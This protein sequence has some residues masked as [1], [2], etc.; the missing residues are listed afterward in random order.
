MLAIFSLP[1][2]IKFLHV[3]AQECVCV[4]G[5]TQHKHLA[6]SLE[7]IRADSFRG[8]GKWREIQCREEITHA[9]VTFSSVCHSCQARCWLYCLADSKGTD[10]NQLCARWQQQMAGN[11]TS[12]EP[13]LCWFRKL[14][15]GGGGR[16]QEHWCAPMEGGKGN[17]GGVAEAAPLPPRP[18]CRIFRRGFLCC[19]N[20]WCFR[21]PLGHTELVAW[22]PES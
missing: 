15:W 11:V 1:N 7:P 6:D 8:G 22:F 17:G 14:Q 13:A 10:Q 9:P 3:F 19:M 12:G 4:W 18:S 2:H 21:N 5:S 16:M 20:D